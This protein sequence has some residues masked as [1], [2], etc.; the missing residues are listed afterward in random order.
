LA[1]KLAGTLGSPDGLEYFHGLKPDDSPDFEPGESNAAFLFHD[2]PADCMGELSV[3]WNEFLQRWLMLYNCGARG[4]AES[5]ILLRAAAQPWGPWSEPQLIFN[6]ARDNGLCHFIHRAVTAA[7][8]QCDNLAGPQQLAESGGGYGPY[9]LARYTT[10]DAA[11]GTTTIYY[12]LSTWIP[13]TE[14]ILMSS[15]TREP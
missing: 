12:T 5:G 9:V 4:P 6:P 10:G 8:P 11:A 15:L 13:Y 14:V 2:S 3:T 7:Q 1:R